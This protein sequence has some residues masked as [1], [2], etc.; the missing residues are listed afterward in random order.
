MIGFIM[1]IAILVVVL[2][3]CVLGG[4]GLAIWLVLKIL[5]SLGG[6]SLARGY[7]AAAEPL[8]RRFTGQT[9]AIGAVRH[10]LSGTVVIGPAGLYCKGAIVSQPALIPWADVRSARDSRIFLK[11]AVELSI[12]NPEVGTITV[13]P[14]L[15]E[16]MRPYLAEAARGASTGRG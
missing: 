1:D 16:P 3:A 2:V 11:P 7:A 13:Y 12:G 10:R 9:I 6:N 8:G 15:F 14:E 4:A 5:R